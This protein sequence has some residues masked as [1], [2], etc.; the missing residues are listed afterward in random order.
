M[1]IATG[2]SGLNAA[3]SMTKAL[4]DGLR[5]GSIRPDEVAGR[6]GEIYD[7]IIDSKVA[8]VDAQA[9]LHKLKVELD[10]IKKDREVFLEGGVD[11]EKRPDGN[12]DGPLCPSCWGLSNKRLPMIKNDTRNNPDYVVYECSHHGAFVA[13]KVPKAVLQKYIK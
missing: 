3:V 5:A 6:I 11:W 9:E 12:Y 13:L 8:L 2:L 1:N 7:Y 10:S 4:R